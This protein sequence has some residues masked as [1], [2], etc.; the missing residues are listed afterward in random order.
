MF[1]TAQLP[2]RGFE[3]DQRKKGVPFC[4]AVDVFHDLNGVEF[5]DNREDYGEE[6]WVIIGVTKKKRLLTVVYTERGPKK[7]IITAWKS[8]REEWRKYNEQDWF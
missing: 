5:I 3:W 4:E 1:M 6:R 8:T 2:P 7:R